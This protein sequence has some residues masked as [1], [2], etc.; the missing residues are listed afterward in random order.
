MW[1]VL[2]AGE[3]PSRRLRL[4]LLR[5]GGVND[6]RRAGPSRLTHRYGQSL[7]AT[8]VLRARTFIPR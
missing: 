3:T 5:L 2:R 8:Y 4:I 1:D 7:G 6:R